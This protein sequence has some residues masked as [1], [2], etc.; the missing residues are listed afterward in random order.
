MTR[1]KDIALIAVLVCTI[2]G[3]ATPMMVG[4]KKEPQ[5]FS[6]SGDP[7]KGYIYVYRENNIFGCV[8]GIYV[9]ANGNRIGGLNNGTYFVY[10]ANPGDVFISVENWLGDNPSR[11]IHV[12]AGKKYYLKGSLKFG[13]LDV[14]PYIERISSEDGERAVESLAYATLTE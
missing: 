7:N 6:P 10:E 3:C 14:T 2:T 12:E 11:K 4:L 1:I 8:R 9:T 5:R 13:S